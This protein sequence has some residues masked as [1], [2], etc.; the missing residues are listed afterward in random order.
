MP[1]GICEEI[2]TIAFSSDTAYSGRSRREPVVRSA[3]RPR[4]LVC[5]RRPTTVPRPSK[6]LP[7]PI[8]RTS[9]A[10]AS[11]SW[12][13]F[14]QPRF[15][16]RR[17]AGT[18]VFNGSRSKSNPT[19]SLNFAQHAAVTQP[20]CQSPSTPETDDFP[21]PARAFFKD[22]RIIVQP[23]DRSQNCRLGSSVRFANLSLESSLCR[24]R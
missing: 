15:K 18:Q 17:F 9:G 1:A 4:R 24:G 11:P 21:Q 2:K 16:D 23:I 22:P 3:R 7:D 14:F 19:T 5:H 20:R 8:R 13:R 10:E 12:M 6:R